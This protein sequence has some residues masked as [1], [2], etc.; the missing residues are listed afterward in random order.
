MTDKIEL[1]VIIPVY[2]EATTCGE[3]IKR[4]KEISIVN[5]I[6]VVVARI[7]LPILTWMISFLIMLYSL[8]SNERF[9][10]E[11]VSFIMD[12]QFQHPLSFG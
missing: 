8:L 12:S 11:I 6:I 7:R 3:I 4:V 1:S 10:F 2:N 5:K 9:N